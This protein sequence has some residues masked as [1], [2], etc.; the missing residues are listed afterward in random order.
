MHGMPVGA[1]VRGKQSEALGGSHPAL[2]AVRSEDY[3]EFSLPLKTSPVSFSMDDNSG[4]PT[5]SRSLQSGL[6][7][8]ERPRKNQQVAGAGGGATEDMQPCIRHAP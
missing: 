5:Y 3:D 6:A 8:A 7:F 4:P 1:M 2:P